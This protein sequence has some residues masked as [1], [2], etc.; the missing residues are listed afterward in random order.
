MSADDYYKILGVSRTASQ[1]EIQKAFHKLATKY[2]PDLNPDQ[3]A[4]QKFQ[5]IRKA[6]EV[7]NDPESRKKYDQLGPLFESI[8]EGGGHTA[9][10]RGFDDIDVSQLF[11]GA[12]G[13]GGAGFGG[14]GFGG[15][16]FGGAGFGGAGGDAFGGFGDIFRQFQPG[17]QAAGGQ[18]AGG[19]ASG[20]GSRRA[21]RPP[22][23]G[24]DLTHQI[25][26]SFTTAILGGE[27]QLSVRTGPGAEARNL[28][29]KIPAGVQDGQTI[30]LRGQGEAGGGM[31]GDLLLTVKVGVHRYYSRR[32]DDLIVRVPV[33]LAEMARLAK[34]DVP[35]PYG[36]VSI[37]LQAGATVGK[38]LRVPGQGVRSAQGDA[39][40]DLLI[41]P[42]IVIPRE[43]D[44]DSLKIIDQLD[45]KW[46]QNPRSDL[47]F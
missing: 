1:D 5:Q 34:I 41:E 22:H 2:H 26:V 20:R 46:Q 4:K 33:T 29:V 21:A 17:G 6:Y 14:A 35:T 19:R 7:L 31:P 27:V 28:S 12:G 15:A 24:R 43:L 13:Y 23:Q 42:Q 39:R 9:D 38:R 25:E 36:T 45:Q 44:A 47:A 18:A 32:G 40:G 37:K 8:Q 16:G 11:G 10:P 30:R 3:R